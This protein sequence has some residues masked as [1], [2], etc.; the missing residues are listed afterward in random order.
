M[1]ADGA[2]LLSGF[3]IFSALL[4]ALASITTHA[5][6]GQSAISR[7]SGVILLLGL[8]TL[9]GMHGLFLADRPSGVASPAYVTLLFVVAPAF[10][11]FVR[12]ALQ[13]PVAVRRLQLVFYVP[14]LFVGWLDPRWAI[15][16]SFLLG[17]G[18]AL[19]LALLVSRLRA[20]RE[21]F[22]LEMFA[23]ALHV[24]LALGILVLGLV[25]PWVGL[26]AFVLGYTIAIGLG[27]LLAMHVLLRFPDI[28]GKAAEA[29]TMA[30][31]VSTLARVDR[32]QAI[33]RLNV[34]MKDERVYTNDALNL[35]T[36][37]ADEG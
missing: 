23:L 21:R 1:I 17:T 32:E 13:L 19:H 28:V 10:Y 25:S 29:V 16:L 36:Q 9:Q 37:R 11:L 24:V 27:F 34:L 4:L 6:E 5:V 18:F 33:S 22:R 20:Q 26:D 8:A 7:L 15:P 2:I 12:G 30:Y 14:A 3:S 35:A 31:A